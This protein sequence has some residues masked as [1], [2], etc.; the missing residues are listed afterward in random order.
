[1]IYNL[2]SLLQIQETCLLQVLRTY[3]QKHYRRRNPESE[4]VAVVHVKTTYVPPKN[5][6]DHGW[7]HVA[8]CDNK[9]E[10]GKELFKL[11]A[12]LW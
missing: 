4:W 7:N 1:M 12:L 9:K 11:L 2:Y 10:D 6:G 8:D 5:R 3:R